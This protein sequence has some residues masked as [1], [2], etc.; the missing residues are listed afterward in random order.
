MAMQTNWT[1]PKNAAVQCKPRE[2][3]EEEKAEI[4]NSP[5]LAEFLK[6]VAPRSE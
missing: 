5:E 6:N 1:Y 3:T 2:F 4:E